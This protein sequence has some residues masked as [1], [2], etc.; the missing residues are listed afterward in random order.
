[1][2]WPVITRLPQLEEGRFGQLTY[3]R[4]YQG[5]LTRGDTIFSMADM[6]KVRVTDDD[7]RWPPQTDGH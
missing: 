7:H 1:M 6:S 4:I 5:R 3:M 2:A